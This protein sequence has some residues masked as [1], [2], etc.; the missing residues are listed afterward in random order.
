M[1]VLV[2]GEF[3]WK[4]YH[5]SCCKALETNGHEVIRFGWTHIFFDWI[6]NL[7]E[8][9]YKTVLHRIQYG[10]LW[11]PLIVKIN[12]NFI[13]KCIN[14]KPDVIWLHMATVIRPGAI[15]SVKSHLPSCK[16]VVYTHDNPFAEDAKNRVWK[17]FYKSIPLAHIRIAHRHADFQGYQGYGQKANFLMRSYFIPQ[18]EFPLPV[19]K[20]P[21]N[22]HC[23]F[24]FAG[25]F[26]DDGRVQY[27]ERLMHL[28]YK[29]NLFGGGW[30]DNS[31]R[32]SDNSPIKNLL[33]IYP[34]VGE[35]YRFAING[36]KVAL[37]FHSTLNQDTYT[38]RSFQI[39]AMKTTML[40]VYS[41]D[42]ASIYTENEISFFSDI[43]GFEQK[44]RKLISDEQLR[45]D[46]AEAAFNRVYN[47]GHDI[48]SR[49][50]YMMHKIYEND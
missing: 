37:S 50:K 29:V 40:S 19:N 4:F 7:P 43:E 15:K 21:V 1:K 5:E 42:L 8:P 39:P 26:E 34:A 28:G 17:N 27:I 3:R 32:L 33:P 16:I 11:G 14:E 2:A 46:K 31:M 44:A 13:F 48:N 45:K 38:T 18:E 49:M 36:A 41:D 22:F 24:V 6:D 25:H 30:N 23:D 10:L 12:K 47:D 9:V 35:N 20:V